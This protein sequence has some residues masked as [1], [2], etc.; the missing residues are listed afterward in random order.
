MRAKKKILKKIFQM[1]VLKYPVIIEIISDVN[2]N[3]QI[4]R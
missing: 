3:I 1:F 2:D 4:Y